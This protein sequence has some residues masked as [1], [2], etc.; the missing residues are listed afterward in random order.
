MQSTSP[1]IRGA[2]SSGYLLLSWLKKVE[3]VSS[4]RKRSTTSTV[5]SCRHSSRAC[6]EQDPQAAA[7]LHSAVQIRFTCHLMA[8]E[9]T[10]H[11]L[12]ILPSFTALYICTI[13]Y[14]TVT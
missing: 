4:E 1:A 6:S 11:V 7:L 3:M 14:C 9:A 12:H 10:A 2:T 8:Q 13:C 5:N